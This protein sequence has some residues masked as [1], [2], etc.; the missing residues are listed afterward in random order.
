MAQLKKKF[1]G[2]SEVGATKIRLENNLELRARNAAD[3]ADVNLLK[4]DASNI[5][6][7]LSQTQISTS[8]SA[9]NDVANKSYVDT[10]VASV[11]SEFDYK[12]SVRVASTAALSIATDLE[13]GDSVDGVTLVTGNRVLL[14]NQ[15][16]PAE[17]GIYIVPASGAASRASD[18]DSDA[19]VTAMSII[20]VSEGTANGDSVWMLTTND[21]I[22]VGTTGLVFAKLGP[23][24]TV[25][26]D[27]I[28]VSGSTVS[29]NHDGEGLTF[30]ANQLALELDGS[31]LSKSASGVKVAAAGITGTE[32]NT[33]V[34][35]DGLAGGGGSALSV[36]VDST[37]IEINAD[38]LRVK[39]AGISAAKLAAGVAG[40]GLSGGAGSAL[41]VNSAFEILT[42]NGTDITNQYKDI[43]VDAILTSIQVSVSGV[44]QT[45]GVDFTVTDEGA[46]SRITFAGDLA[47][48]GNAALV[49]G[50]VLNVSYITK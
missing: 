3:S 20:P 9:A 17:N 32:L 26:G 31:T 41:S 43:A 28:S 10:R 50:D 16:D 13:N 4:L 25:A 37:T 30:V 36:N 35:G 1:I 40:D 11:L 46:N 45:S 12:A 34:A 2:N 23:S 49:S 15:A 21:P 24:S 19:E 29:V 22:V 7:L 27:G 42:L 39:D 38:S 48:G 6:Q 18:F 33:S 47:T 8:P 14:K 5:V 44:A